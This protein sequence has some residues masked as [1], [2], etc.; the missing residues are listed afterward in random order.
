[1]RDALIQDATP[2]GR[3]KLGVEMLYCGR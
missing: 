3:W 2:P 1:M